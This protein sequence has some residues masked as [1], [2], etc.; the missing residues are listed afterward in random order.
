MEYGCGSCPATK[1]LISH[2]CEKITLDSV[3]GTIGD[4][5][6]KRISGRDRR[7]QSRRSS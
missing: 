7:R 2:F 1:F 4:I 3:T 6:A 5:A